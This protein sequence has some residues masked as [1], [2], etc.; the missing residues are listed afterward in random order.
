MNDLLNKGV[1]PCVMMENL[2]NFVYS[3]FRRLHILPLTSTN[4]SR[5]KPSSNK[6]NGHSFCVTII[7][8]DGNRLHASEILS[9]YNYHLLKSRSS[10]R[11]SLSHNQLLQKT[12][13]ITYVV[14]FLLHEDSVHYA[15]L[16]IISSR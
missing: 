8:Y 5:L 15:L 2:S 7:C 6:C 1:I 12:F 11:S 14:H 16:T 3:N 10:V 4:F 13:T 9:A